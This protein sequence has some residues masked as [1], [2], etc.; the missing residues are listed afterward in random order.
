MGLE[1]KMVE[2]EDLGRQLLL[3]NKRLGVDEM[4]ARIEMLTADDLKRVARRVIFN[5]DSESPLNFFDP[6]NKPWKRTGK[7]NPTVVIHGP[8]SARDPL[9]D[10]EKTLGDWKIGKVVKSGKKFWPF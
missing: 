2:L 8:L 7:G 5:E 9:R 6:V 3:N 1:S 4:C 10:V